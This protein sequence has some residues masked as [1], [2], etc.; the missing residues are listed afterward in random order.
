MPAE[1]Q[2]TLPE[3]GAS[4]PAPGLERDGVVRHAL[5][6]LDDVGFSGLTLRRLAGRLNVKAAALYWHF[7]NKQDLIDAMAEHVIRQEFE[8]VAAP[9]SDWRT[10]LT[11][12]AATHRR[13]LLRHRDGA[14]LMAHA[15]LRQSSMLRDMEKL[16]GLLRAQGMSGELAL[17]SMFAIIRYT[18]GCVFEEQADPRSPAERIAEFARR[19][20][21]IAQTSPELAASVQECLANP[22]AKPEHMFEQGL[23]IILDGIAHRL[24]KTPLDAPQYG[25]LR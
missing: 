20:Q 2:P 7:E 18:L 4:R 9:A 10:I 1:P 6:L 22:S 16:L 25:D 23:A 8:R 14:L 5:Q 3:D 12:V 19:W 17:G 11:M 21:T 24:R 15:N 13:A